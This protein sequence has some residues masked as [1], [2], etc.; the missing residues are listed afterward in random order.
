MTGEQLI[1]RLQAH[2]DARLAG[3]VPPERLTARVM[4]IPDAYPLPS[5]RRRSGWFS[6][7]LGLAFAAVLLL[8]TTLAAALLGGALRKP[9][10][11]SVDLGI[12]EPI[13]GWV[14][15]GTDDG[16]WGD[17]PDGPDVKLAAGAGTPLGW[18][19]D[20][21]R[22][23][24]LRD[25]LVILHGD[26]S[27]TRLTT[28]SLRNGA[29]SLSADGSRVVF[30]GEGGRLFAVDADGGPA[31][32]LLELEGL[33]GVS[34]APDGT[35]I[36]YVSGRGDSGHRVTVMDA[37]G[38]NPREILANDKTLGG[39]HDHGLT[40]SPAGDRIALGIEGVIYTF[41]PDGS[42]F[43]VALRGGGRRQPFWSP[44]GSQVETRGPW[45]PGVPGIDKPSPS[46]GT[47]AP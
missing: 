13:S 20:G 33:E 32:T 45:H 16:I 9:L 30:L 21:T 44:D 39:G 29:A 34:L 8:A 14:V 1:R 15:Y 10:Q 35:R 37:D 42:G 23:L 24:V 17:N 27:E 46:P 5:P 12:F 36:A 41:A 40:W 38:S 2:F 7:P 26:G 47:T 43:T 6:R 3:V 19:R 11:P 25:G 18:S 22:L 31:E 28:D 4:A